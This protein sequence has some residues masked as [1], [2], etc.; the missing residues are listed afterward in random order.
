M[1][2]DLQGNSNVD[3]KDTSP[4][5]TPLAITVGATDITD[6]RAYYSNFG[7]NVDVFAPG[8]NVTSTWNDGGVK[9]ISGTSMATPAVAGLVAYYLNII[10]QKTPPVVMSLFLQSQAD[11]FKL[12]NVRKST[13]PCMF[14]FISDSSLSYLQPWAPS[15]SLRSTAT[16]SDGAV[17]SE[18]CNTT[19]YVHTPLLV[20][21]LHNPTVPYIPQRADILI[22]LFFLRCNSPQAFA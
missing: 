5:N 22:Q 9:T 13:F 1:L 21:P 11:L 15:T 4:A 2:N 18:Q 8:S 14:T 16:T 7:P 19:L 17:N 10:G 12:S 6:S 3:A 20:Y